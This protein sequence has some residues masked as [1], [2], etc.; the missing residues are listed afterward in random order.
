MTYFLLECA[1][2]GMSLLSLW[3]I[4]S[5]RTRAGFLIGALDVIPWTILA[6]TKWASPTMLVLE[7]VYLVVNLR[8]FLRTYRTKGLTPP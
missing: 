1:A 5:G 7:A 8:G 6:L 2:Y 4:S 3:L